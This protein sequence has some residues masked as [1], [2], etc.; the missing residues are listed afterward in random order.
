MSRR[1]Y[2]SRYWKSARRYILARDKYT[3]YWCKGP[4]NQV[5]HLTPLVEGGQPYD[6]SNLV[7]SCISCNA[8]RGATSG[9]SR[10]KIRGANG[11]NTRFFKKGSA[12]YPA[13]FKRENCLQNGR[14]RVRFG[15]IDL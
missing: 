13:V 12:R 11:L 3:C 1:I 4:A 15:A 10:R 7:A 14:N 6:P 2:N 8:S 9:N 5:D